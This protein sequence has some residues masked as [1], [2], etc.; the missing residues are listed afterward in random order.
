[1][2]KSFI[3]AILCIL[4]ILIPSISQG[5]KRALLVGINDYKYLPTKISGKGK[6]SDLRGSLNDVKMMRDVL[7]SRY[8]F[9]S[10]G[11]KILTEKDAS[12]KN[13][14]KTF[15]EWL[16][17]GSKAGD[18]VL[19]FFSGHGSHVRDFNGDEEDGVDEVLCPY[20][21]TIFG[22]RSIILDDELGAWLRRLEDRDVVVIIDSCHSGTMTRSIGGEAVSVLEKTPSSQSRL[23]PII[24]YKPAY[25]QAK[26]VSPVED[27]PEGQIFMA[28]SKEY[29][30]AQ[31][32]KTSN[33][34]HFGAFTISVA[35]GLTKLSHP[36]YLRLYEYTTKMVKDILKLNQDPQIEPSSQEILSRPVFAS[37]SPDT[38][39]STIIPPETKKT[40]STTSI[41]QMTSIPSTTTII[42]AE[43]I[44]AISIS[45][46]S[47]QQTTSIPSTST[48]TIA[49]TII[50]ELPSDDE[51]KETKLTVAI[52]QFAGCDQPTMEH[53]R[54]GI[55]ALPYVKMVGEGEFF[56][57]LIRGK[58]INGEISARVLNG[59]GDVTKIE[60][61]QNIDELV[62]NI[63]PH[64]E[65]AY[66]VKQL[67]FITNPNP[68]FKVKIWVTDEKRRDFRVGEKIVF[69]LWAERDCHL[70]MLNLDKKGNFHIIFPNQ[71]HKE[72]F[73][74]GEK[75]VK[76]PG[77]R[78]IREHFEFM[79][80]RPAG[81]ETVKVIA[82]SEKL[83][84]KKLG[85]GDFKDL[86][87]TVSGSA[88]TQSSPSRNL[89]KELITTLREAD[90]MW[91]ED[92]VVVR[93]HE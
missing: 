26:G 5:A 22:G 4:S 2:N 66:M 63:A 61:V 31:E 86:F 32:L 42:P 7:V 81:E 13:I 84:L 17:T 3:F 51:V 15:N 18:L 8:G 29:Q 37:R 44:E 68:P 19:F 82:T 75:T 40:T 47:I 64:M 28:A 57:R 73:I 50:P 70:L 24:D 54:S 27:E 87:Q 88:K 6:F 9:T 90:F 35:T 85:L 58:M 55:S 69:N 76:I 74:K 53:I 92:T 14:E 43:K 25:T 93:S 71:Y 33:G 16:V 11:I 79:F 45:T 67:A 48:T 1:M 12:K 38:T 21:A 36:T 83:D 39:T 62:N 77:E 78:M 34:I 23:V 59:I 52:E 49:I 91:S 60:T 65:Y 46:T 41:Q 56:E 30:I 10:H 72:S 80:D 89:V 20:N